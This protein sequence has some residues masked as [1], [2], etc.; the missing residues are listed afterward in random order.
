MSEQTF[1]EAIRAGLR[2]EMSRDSAVY[3]FGE[4]VSLG[5]PFGVTK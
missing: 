4:D 3:L 2:E 5:G 1:L